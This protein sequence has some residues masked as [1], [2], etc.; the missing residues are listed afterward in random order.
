MCTVRLQHIWSYGVSGRVGSCR[1]LGVCS[2]VECDE[3]LFVA[4]ETTGTG[5]GK[6]DNRVDAPDKENEGGGKAIHVH[7]CGGG[8]WRPT[9]AICNR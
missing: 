8:E 1:G 5:T 4:H 6:E 3:Q 9:T 2:I 7:I